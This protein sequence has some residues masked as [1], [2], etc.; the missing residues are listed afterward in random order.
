MRK[1]SL[2][3]LFLVLLM[4][5]G[6]V[7][8]NQEPEEIFR[9]VIKI[10]AVIPENARTAQVL[11]TEREGHGVVIDSDGHVLTIGYLILEAKTIEITGPDGKIIDATFVGYDYNS[12]FGLL[13]ANTSLN[14]QPMKLGQSSEVKVGDPVLVVGH[15]GLDAAQGA[16][17][18]ARREFAGYWEYLLE[19]AI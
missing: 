14:V 4:F 6:L 15:G 2:I 17:V 19:E 5:C 1:G 18:V 8:A 3:V 9:A 13:R 16:Y 10:R 12:G 7:Y 11:G